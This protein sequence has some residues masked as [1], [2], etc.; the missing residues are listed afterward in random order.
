MQADLDDAFGLYVSAVR[1]EI[2]PQPALDFWEM[3]RQIHTTIQGLLTDKQIFAALDAAQL[4]PTLLDALSF[5]KYGM[6]ENDLAKRLL[7]R[8]GNDGV[9]V[10]LLLTNLGRLSIQTDFPGLRIAS[11]YGPFV[12]SDT[13]ERYLAH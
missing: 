6:C 9:H 3:T 7:E 1:T 12:Y 13:H 11:I 2:D 10:G 8:S 5:A 4:P